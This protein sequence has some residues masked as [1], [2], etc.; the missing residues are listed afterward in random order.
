MERS[1]GERYGIADGMTKELAKGVVYSCKFI[2][3]IEQR[4]L[5]RSFMECAICKCRVVK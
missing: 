4:G 5:C 2:G 3:N 1:G